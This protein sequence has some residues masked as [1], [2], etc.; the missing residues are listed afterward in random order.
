MS[1][2]YSTIT[3]R[4]PEALAER[5]N[6]WDAAG[7]KPVGSAFPAQ[8]G[9]ATVGHAMLLAREAPAPAATK[10]TRKRKATAKPKAK[11]GEK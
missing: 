6:E 11:A 10:P 7:W 1:T 4:S 8:I 2:I 3:E 9:V 5:L